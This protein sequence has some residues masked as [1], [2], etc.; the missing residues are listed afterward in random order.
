MA[1]DSNDPG[2]VDLFSKLVQLHEKD[3]WFVR[4][5]L[6]KKDGLV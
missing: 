6:K 4:E 5:I 1:D 3:E 2:T